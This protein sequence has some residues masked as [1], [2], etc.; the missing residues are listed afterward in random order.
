MKNTSIINMMS[1]SGGSTNS[2][3]SDHVQ[4]QIHRRRF[5]QQLAVYG[6]E[7][8]RCQ[9][10][11]NVLISGLQ[12]LGVEM[13]VYLLII[14]IFLPA[15][16]LLNFITMKLWLIKHVLFWLHLMTRQILTL[17]PVFCYIFGSQRCDT[18]GSE[19]N[20]FA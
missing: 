3:P 19:I 14:S 2:I 8:I 9:A 15:L 4:M 20:D 11:A 18:S 10:S 7:A 6:R 16:I 5:A 12:G 1:A 13:G 17:P